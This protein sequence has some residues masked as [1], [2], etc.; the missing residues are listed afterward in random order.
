M[1][2]KLPQFT[3]APGSFPCHNCMKYVMEKIIQY[4][5]DSLLID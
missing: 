5:K 4:F 3:L 2:L 1:Y